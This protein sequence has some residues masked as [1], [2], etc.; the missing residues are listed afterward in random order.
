MPLASSIPRRFIRVLKWTALAAALFIAGVWAGGNRTAFQWMQPLGG[1]P[2]SAFGESGG[3]LVLVDSPYLA[4]PTT[5]NEMRR[6]FRGVARSWLEERMPY[7]Q[8]NVQGTLFIAIPY[9][10]PTLMLASLA[11]SLF[12]LDHR[13]TRRFGIGRCPACNYTLAGLPATTPCPECGTNPKNAIVP[14]KP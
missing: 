3:V 2:I 10:L 11:V 12:W 5:R 4:D 7:A 13:R 9:W 6:D 14:V 1:P 8:T